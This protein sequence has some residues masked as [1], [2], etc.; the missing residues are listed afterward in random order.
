MTKSL[1]LWLEGPMQSWGDR[2]LFGSRETLSFPTKS[3]IIGLL[4]CAMGRSGGQEDSLEELRSSRLDIFC[5][6]RKDSKA[7][8]TVIPDFHMVGNGYDDKDPWSNLR[9]P[10]NSVGKKAN[11]G[12]AKLTRRYYLQDAAFACI[13]TVPE[14]WAIAMVNGLQNPKWPV[15]LG[16]KGCPPSEPIFSGCFAT[17]DEAKLELIELLKES[18]WIPFEKITEDWSGGHIGGMVLYDVPV[19]FGMHKKYASRKVIRTP[20]AEI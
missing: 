4:F 8:P 1:L 13:L 5:L 20:I 19:S 6:Q 12:G 14:K 2:S 15:Y 7:L 11:N 16:R 18:S 10:K 9:I 3:G 17:P